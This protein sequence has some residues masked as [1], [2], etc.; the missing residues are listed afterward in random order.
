MNIGID[1]SQIAYPATGVGRYTQ[2]LVEAILDYDKANRWIFVFSSFRGRIDEKLK[3]RILASRHRFI[4]L[5][6]SPKLLSFISNT[7]HIFPIEM[8]TGQLDWFITSDW[9]EPPA[10]CKKATIIHDLTFLRYPEVVHKTILR[11]QQKRINHVQRESSLIIAVSNTTRKDTTDLLQ[12]SSSK[13]KTIYTGVTTHIPDK[14]TLDYIKNKFNIKKPF[15]LSVGKLEPRKNMERLITSWNEIEHK[16]YE[17]IIVGQKGWDFDENNKQNRGVRFLGKVSDEELNALYELCAFFIYPSLWEG[18][19]YPIIEAM[20]HNKAVATSNT[21]SLKEL[22]EGHSIL[23]DPTSPEEI[24][25]TLI[26]LMSDSTLRSSV[27]TKGYEYARRFTWKTY[28]EHLI[29]ELT[30][31]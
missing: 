22:G 19:G 21:S 4:K 26:T 18:F 17:L 8:V 7:L 27:A 30:S 25:K 31:Q 23:F 20:Q 1:I 15:V 13:V 3:K 16:A 24:K 6:F 2:G 5:P 9:T 28:M 29:S 10:Q 14:K 11:T 12:I